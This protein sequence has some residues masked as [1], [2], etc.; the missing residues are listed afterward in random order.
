MYLLTSIDT[1]N[2][3]NL[4]KIMAIYAS[5]SY[6]IFPIIGLHIRK[7]KEGITHGMIL[8]TIVS[9]FLWFKYGS[10]MIKLE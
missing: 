5:I 9:I 4:L 10:K 1:T 7:N 8:G 2:R 3:N 6:F